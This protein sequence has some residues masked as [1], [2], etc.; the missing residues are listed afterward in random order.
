MNRTGSLYGWDSMIAYDFSNK[1]T[2]VSWN[3]GNAPSPQSH[4][5]YNQGF[6]LG[7]QLLF[8]YRCA[9]STSTTC[10][11]V[12]NGTS[13]SNDATMIWSP[14]AIRVNDAWNM[15]KGEIEGAYDPISGGV[16]TRYS[17]GVGVQNLT[18]SVEGADLSIDV[19]MTN[20]T[21]QYNA[22]AASGSGSGSG[23]SNEFRQQHR[24]E[25]HIGFSHPINRWI[26]HHAH[27]VLFNG[28]ISPRPAA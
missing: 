25:N 9:Q 16:G 18:A 2:Q 26:S 14:Y 4:M 20:I 15:S 28:I 10:A 3:L 24:T 6:A 19:P 22:G 23:A 5:V 17:P 12:N 13:T 27:R 1:S 11:R 7:D 8:P 21:F